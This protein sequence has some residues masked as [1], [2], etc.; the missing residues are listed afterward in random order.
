MSR[1]RTNDVMFFSLP[2]AIFDR[3]LTHTELIV[4]IVLYKLADTYRDKY[5]DRITWFLETNQTL[6][7]YAKVSLRSITS[8]KAQLKNLGLI[9]F[10]VESRA[11]G[12]RTRYFL[13]SFLG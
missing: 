5:G 2:H 7:R 8:A 4:L 9:D 6:A 11:Y 3:G 1:I 13:K 12:N 10:W